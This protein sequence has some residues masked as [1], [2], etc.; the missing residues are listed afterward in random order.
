MNPEDNGHPDERAVRAAYRQLDAEEPPDL[1]DQAVLNRARAAAEPPAGRRPWS[2]GWVHG[3]TTAGLV[4]LG[5]GI[6]LQLREPVVPLPQPMPPAELREDDALQT[7]APTP[8]AEE[9]PAAAR[10]RSADLAA[11]VEDATAPARR[12]LR[13]TM[14]APPPTAQGDA[15]A[16][17]AAAQ[18][19]PMDDSS[20]S[21]ADFEVMQ[22]MSMEAEDLLESP[23]SWLARIRDLQAAGDEEGFVEALA[24]FREAYP[25][26][27]LPE[28]L[29]P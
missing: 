15:P 5:L 11:P 17:K 8:L 1:V 12:E 22:E 29:Q 24:A 7:A 28:D 6:F 27:P 9:A 18:A 3:L 16:A 25:D 2:F 20:E 19:Q 23:E 4:V 14:A 26:Y 21:I 13:R 10:T